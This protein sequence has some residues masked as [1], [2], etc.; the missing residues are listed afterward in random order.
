M[1]NLR[2]AAV[3]MAFIGVTVAMPVP[4]AD[5]SIVA[6]PGMGTLAAHVSEWVTKELT[7]R[8]VKMWS[9]SKAS[10]TT[11]SPSVTIVGGNHMII[12]ARRLAPDFAPLRGLSGPRRKQSV[13]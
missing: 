2:K 3:V 1:N 5:T 9:A 12:E 7:I 10:I 4:A 13:P 6:I 11:R 8:A